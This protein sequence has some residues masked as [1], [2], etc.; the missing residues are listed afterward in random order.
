M[1]ASPRDAQLLNDAAR[2]EFARRGA[3]SQAVML[4]VRAFGANPLDPEVAGYLA[5]LLLRQHPVQAEP[6]RQLALYALTL[7][8]P[9]NPRGRAE[10]WATL[11]VAN[12][13]SGRER[14][15]RNAWLVSLSLAPSLDRQCRAA[16]DAYAM[17]GERLRAPVEAMLYSA[18]ASGRSLQSSFCEWPPHWTVSSG[19]MR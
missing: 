10:D 5:F 9:R 14:D 8:D 18:H 2:N 12:A 4:Q 1:A 3:T 15:A 16:I 7:R 11:A 13:L 19:S 6:V 17:H